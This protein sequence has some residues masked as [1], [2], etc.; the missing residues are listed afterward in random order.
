MQNKMGVIIGFAFGVVAFLYLFKLIILDHVP[1]SDELAP[2][3][4]VF[5]RICV[6]FYW[7]FNSEPF[8]QEEKL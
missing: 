2:G 8:Y 4:V 5:I 3:V 6:C 7:F 1:P